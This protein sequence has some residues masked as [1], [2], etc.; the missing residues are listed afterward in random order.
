MQ[1]ELSSSI[2]REGQV[3]EILG[4]E[5]MASLV[6][7]SKWHHKQDTPVVSLD[8]KR[9]MKT[10]HGP[11]FVPSVFDLIGLVV[12][13]TVRARLLLKK[14]WRVSGQK[15]DDSL[16]ENLTENLFEWHSWLIIIGPLKICTAIFSSAFDKTEL[17]MFDY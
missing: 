7:G 5:D 12:Q 15:W 8:V 16:P 13:C 14:V 1:N 10:T 2:V 17:P 11:N 9:E 6:L 4:S 3:E